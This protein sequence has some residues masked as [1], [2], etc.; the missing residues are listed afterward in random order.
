MVKRLK[1][2]ALTLHDKINILK[3][4]DDNIGTRKRSEIELDLN[5][6]HSTL[7]YIL[8]DRVDIE[9]TYK[10]RP[11]IGKRK[12]A[13]AGKY[14]FLEKV[15]MEWYKET[16]ASK[17]AINGPMLSQKAHDV[18]KALNINDFTGSNGWLSRFKKR[19]GIFLKASQ[20]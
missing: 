3:Y 5:I 20:L 4:F 2:K 10:C 14:D 6:P 11:D 18:A 9:N 1:R 16:Q 15:L 17:T 13:R 8:K 7:H 12:R 19:N